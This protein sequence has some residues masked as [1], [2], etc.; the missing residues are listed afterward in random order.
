MCRWKWREEL[1]TLWW[2]VDSWET[3]LEALRRETMEEIWGVIIAVKYLFDIS[4]PSPYHEDTN[5]INKVYWMTLERYDDLKP[6]LEIEEIVRVSKKDWK[7][8]VYTTLPNNKEM[9]DRV[10]AEWYR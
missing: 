6:M 1:W 8:G 2:K 10:E 9:I 3:E 7:N 4:W 5:S